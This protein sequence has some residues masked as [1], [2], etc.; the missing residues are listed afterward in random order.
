MLLSFCLVVWQLHLVVAYESAAYIKK[1]IDRY[2]GQQKFILTLHALTYIVR[3]YWT[4]WSFVM[5]EV[6][7]FLEQNFKNSFTMLN[8]INFFISEMC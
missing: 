3:H 2:R 8:K 4:D 1:H 5:C 6:F 7:K